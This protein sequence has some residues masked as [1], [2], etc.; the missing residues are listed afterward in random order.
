MSIALRRPRA[1]A[2]VAG[3]TAAAAVSA[4]GPAAAATV[5]G[6]QTAVTPDPGLV[7]ALTGLGAKVGLTGAATA[8]ASGRFVYPITGGS[9][10]AD[11]KGK[12]G[13]TGGLQITP[14]A[15]LKFGIQQ[16]VI[17]TRREPQLTAVPTL[18]GFPLGIRVPVATITDVTVTSAPPATVVKGTVKL[19][20]IGALYINTFLGTSAVKRG[21]VFGTAEATVTL[22]S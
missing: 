12:I 21:T 4:A 11:L 9:L 15:G 14:K 17:D 10:T 18:A 3:V 22:G 5:T 2:L 7:T 6:T 13:H 20:D 16:F 8:D 1:L 19:T